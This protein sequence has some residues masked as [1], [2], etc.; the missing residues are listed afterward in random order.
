[1]SS[2][3]AL[4]CHSSNCCLSLVVVVVVFAIV[5]LTQR[6]ITHK[7]AVIVALKNDQT[8]P[9]YTYCYM[10]LTAFFLRQPG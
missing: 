8:V 10:H 7:V 6:I 1:M 5:V 9:Q 3:S 4:N 2:T